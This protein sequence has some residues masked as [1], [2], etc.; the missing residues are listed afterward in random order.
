MIRALITAV[1]IAGAATHYL[2]VPLDA[3]VGY[4]F[5]LCVGGWFLWPVLRRPLRYV[6]RFLLRPLRPR[7]RTGRAIAPR[8]APARATAAPRDVPAQITQINHHHYYNGMPPRPGAPMRPDY[9]LTALPRRTEGRIA[10]DE[11]LDGIID[12]DIDDD[13]TR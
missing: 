1:L 12:V 4:A 13:T 5:V 8:P 3:A 6:T 2:D 9:T 7:R 10:S 11:I